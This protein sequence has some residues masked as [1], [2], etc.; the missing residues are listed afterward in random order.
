M[1]YNHQ[2]YWYYRLHSWLSG[3]YCRHIVEPQFDSIGDGLAVLH[4]RSLKLFGHNI[5]AGRHLHLICSRD[6]PIGLSTWSSKNQQG[7][8]QIGDFCLISPGV[9]I[10]SAEK[11]TI[12]KNCMIAADAYISDSD[13]HGLYNRTRPFRC[14]APVSIA[15]NVWIGM[16]A[17]VGKGV[18][19]GENSVVAAG[20]VVVEDVEAN[21]VVGGNPAR[22]IKRLK[23]DKRRLTREFL[24]SG[25]TDYADNQQQ[26][27]HY[28][29]AN[30]STLRWIKSLIKPSK[31]N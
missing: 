18:K 16:R 27:N 24:F 17:V 19:I 10:A 5:H 23:A 13:W 20:S 1:R 8:I 28:L 21:V 4:P 22:V 12:G 29:L 6:K 7:Y 25:A 15:D 9:T 31:L 30:N 3:L 14:S 11:I 2:P 26:L